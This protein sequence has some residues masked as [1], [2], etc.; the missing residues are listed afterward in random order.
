MELTTNAAKTTNT[1]ITW[2]SLPTPLKQPT[3]TSHGTHYHRYL[4]NQQKHNH[5]TEL[6]TNATKGTNTNITWN[7]LSTP[8][9]EQTQTSH[10]THYQRH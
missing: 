8:L 9:K 10:G 4:N 7:S 2:N 1:N 5:H 3:Q 6:T